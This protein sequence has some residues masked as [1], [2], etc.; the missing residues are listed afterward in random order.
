MRLERKLSIYILILVTFA[1]VGIQF[2][3]FKNIT[4]V[5][6][7][8]KKHSLNGYSYVLSKENKIRD[9]LL[10]DDYDSVDQHLDQVWRKLI[11][12]NY[13]L[14]MDKDGNIISYKDKK[15]SQIIPKDIKLLAQKEFEKIS[16]DPREYQFTLQESHIEE[17]DINLSIDPKNNFLRQ[18]VPIIYKGKFIGILGIQEYYNKRNDIRNTLFE[19]LT[20]T[21]ALILAITILFSIFLAQN[22]KKGTLGLDPI[23]IGKFYK[24][25][26]LIFDAISDE[27]VTLNSNGT[28]TKMNK[29]AE[30]NL[31]KN[32]ELALKKLYDEIISSGKVF[33]DREYK[34]TS[35]IVYISSLMINN[36]DDFFDILFIIRSS[37][38]VKKLAE[39]ITGVTQI[40]NSMRANVH[41]FKNKIH[42][43]SGLLRLEEYE[44]AK[45]YVSN[46]KTELDIEN[47]EVEGINDPIIKA[48][49]LTKINLAK[50]R[51]ITLNIDEDS[52]L[53]TSHKTISPDDLIVIIGNLIE[54]AMESFESSQGNKEINS[55]FLEDS[56]KIYIEVSDNGSPIKNKENIFEMGVSSKGEGRGSGLALIKNLVSVYNGTIN[57]NVEGDV[58]TF[59]IELIKEEI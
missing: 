52:N 29:T 47:K 7:I 59:S 12:L 5:I 41:E 2:I 27:I 44:Q 1:V 23:D 51:K 26:K 8:N 55:Y 31:K 11:N 32:D 56:K 58:K 33:S 14:V 46:I 24:E 21:T 28:I 10:S 49:L 30:K 18:F 16:K 38:K 39:E 13:L 53:M 25:R 34:L 15:N 3:I 19:E 48:L 22:I 57:I 36:E 42:V 54:N 43:I 6:N 45:N 20:L 37:E 9:E 17:N 4:N 35:G 40:I 50:E